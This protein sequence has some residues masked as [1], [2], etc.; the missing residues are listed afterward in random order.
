M[1]LRVSLLALAALVG[2]ASFV[3]GADV[4][5]QRFGGAVK[6]PKDAP[7]AIRLPL[8]GALVSG[9]IQMYYYDGGFTGGHNI[10]VEASFI[11]NSTANVFTSM[12]VAFFD[13]RNNL[14]TGLGK[15]E[16]FSVGPGK[17]GTLGLDVSV[18]VAQFYKISKYQL[19][20][21]DDGK[22]IGRQ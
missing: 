17:S 8:K 20:F 14:I 11:N 19:V 18:P 21:Y 4:D 3:Y 7:A 5:C 12:G 6:L 9:N 16:V 13:D 10:K 15:T 22:T 1:K 2:S